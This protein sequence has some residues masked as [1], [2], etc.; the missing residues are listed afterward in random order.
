MNNEK[1]LLTLQEV[2]K[3]LRLSERTIHRLKDDGKI[4]YIKV[5]GVFRFDSIAI[6]EWLKNGGTDA[7]DE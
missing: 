7:K 6:D 2:A 3:L 5:G 4:P 1:R